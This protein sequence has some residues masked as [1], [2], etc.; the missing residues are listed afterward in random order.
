MQC[1]LISVFSGLLGL[2]LAGCGSGE[3][4]DESSDT[5]RSRDS[6]QGGSEG[7]ESFVLGTHNKINGRDCG[8]LEIREKSKRAFCEK[9]RSLA[10]T[11]PAGGDLCQDANYRSL[12]NA[13]LSSGC[14][15]TLGGSVSGTL[16]TS[17]SVATEPSH[18]SEPRP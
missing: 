13:D 4:L 9:I 5:Q 16:N 3:D 11:T 10:P 7:S 2:G 12:K 8:K 17:S 1:V 14:Q 15:S 6:A 18:A